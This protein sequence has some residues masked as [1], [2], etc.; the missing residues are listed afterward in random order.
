MN[1]PNY[2]PF[3]DM[4]LFFAIVALV[5]SLVVLFAG[6]RLCRCGPGCKCGPG[7]E[8]PADCPGDCAADEDRHT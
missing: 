7:C 1:F 6:P 2:K 3:Q 4:I 8:C 5:I